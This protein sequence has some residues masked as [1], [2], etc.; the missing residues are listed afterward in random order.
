MS[1]ILIAG[2]VSIFLIFQIRIRKKPFTFVE[3]NI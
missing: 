2:S 1:K 3:T